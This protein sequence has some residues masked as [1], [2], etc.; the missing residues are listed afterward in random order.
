MAKIEAL[1]NDSS[2]MNNLPL[3]YYYYYIPY[4]NLEFGKFLGVCSAIES[5]TYNPFINDDNVTFL[6]TTYD[7]ERYGSINNGSCTIRRIMS[8]SEIQSILSESI[9][10]FDWNT[11]FDIKLQC[12][13]YTYFLIT[14]YMN[15]PLLVKPQLVYNTDNKLI[16]KIETTPIS[17]RYRLYVKNNKNDNTGKLEGII[18]NMTYQLPVSSSAY[19]QFYASSM[20]SFNSNISNSLIENDITLKQNVNTAMLNTKQSEF[21][22][23]LSAIASLLTGNIGG[24]VSNTVS[25]LQQ[26]EKL[27]NLIYNLNEKSKFKESEIIS[28]KNAKI[29]DLLNTPNSIK[30]A[31]ND[32]VFNLTI[33][34][35]KID[36]IKYTITPQ[37]KRRIN[38]YFKRYGYAFNDYAIPDIYSRQHYNFLK[39]S[40]C[41]LISDTIPREHQEEIKE[42]FET[43]ITM[44]HMENGVTPLDYSVSNH[45][46][47][48]GGKNGEDI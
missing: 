15:E 47:Q 28:N 33:N 17:G 39:C 19:S 22:S 41:Q 26:Q 5:L 4:N 23:G 44:W 34:N 10:L 16:I 6:E 1:D 45:I 37:Y 46:T 9:K 20:S 13:P 24:T 42:I 36:V 30:T 7:K 31:G 3:G 48:L 8:C 14:D 38:N 40:V 18:N 12:Y 29:N 11:P 35:R 21:N 32:S 2:N 25:L 43:G 27:D